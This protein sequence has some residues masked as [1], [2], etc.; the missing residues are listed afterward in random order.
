VRLTSTALV[1]EAPVMV[2]ESKSFT[3]S[4]QT[5]KTTLPMEP[6]ESS[7]PTDA[8]SRLHPPLIA[9]RISDAAWA[10]SPLAYVT[11]SRMS[12]GPVAGRLPAVGAVALHGP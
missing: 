9:Y 4:P 1:A 7:T 2:P 8:V 11:P 12:G 5:W 3:V 6:R 10:P